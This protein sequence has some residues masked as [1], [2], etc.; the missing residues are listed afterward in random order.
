M[1]GKKVKVEHST[2]NEHIMDEHPDPDSG[3][4]K[5]A[6]APQPDPGSGGDKPAPATDGDINLPD[7]EADL[8]DAD[9]ELLQNDSAGLGLFP[10][11]PCVT[12]GKKCKRESTVY[13]NRYGPRRF[14]W[15]VWSAEPQ[16]EVDVKKLQDVGDKLERVLDY[17]RK[18]SQARVTSGYVKGIINMVWD[19]PGLEGDPLKAAE[20]LNPA[21]VK[22]A[23]ELPT[24]KA[25]KEWAAKQS[26]KKLNPRL[27]TYP[28]THVEVTYNQDMQSFIRDVDEPITKRWELGSQY[29]ALYRSTGLEMEYRVYNSAKSQATRFL[30]WYK[31]AN[32]EAYE[33]GRYVASRSVSRDPTVQPLGDGFTSREGS[34]GAPASTIEGTTSK[35]GSPVAGGAAG[36]AGGTAS[37]ESSPAATV[38]KPTESKKPTKEAVEMAAKVAYGL[39]IKKSVNEFDEVDELACAMYTKMQL[40]EYGIS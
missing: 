39:K 19:C 3:G 40:E 23:D 12:V 20:L 2:D 8:L 31:T 36:T 7:A 35:E 29:R 16:G 21:L 33:N 28:P 6:P 38:S 14:G 9:P 25:R 27:P 26:E 22:R 5:P 17:P 24:L 10:N 15:F 18:K 37:K 34:A 30:E 4:D 11:A 1:S 13:L 32:P